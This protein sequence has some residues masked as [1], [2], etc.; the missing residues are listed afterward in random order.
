MKRPLRRDQPPNCEHFCPAFK[1]FTYL[2]FPCNYSYVTTQLKLIIILLIIKMSL[3]PFCGIIIQHFFSN[4]DCLG[5]VDNLTIAKVAFYLHPQI[6]RN[7]RK[8][9][10]TRLVRELTCFGD[11]THLGNLYSNWLLKNYGF[12]GIYIP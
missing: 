8:T 6:M 1:A 3:K 9:D 4:T 10:K 2:R 5:S 11:R 12:L 7:I